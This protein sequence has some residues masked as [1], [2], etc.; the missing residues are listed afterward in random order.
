MKFCPECGSMLYYIEEGS[1]LY[2]KCKSCG[3]STECHDRIIES[4]IYTVS[5]TQISE[6]KSYMRYDS[7]L[8]RTI[9]KECPNEDCQSRKDKVFQE[10]VFYPDPL[11]MKLIY[12]CIICN[13][14]WKYS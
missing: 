1:V 10:A 11:T 7:T 9:H 2:T 12:I 6:N 14:E 13:T 4:S 5:N 8:P 3:Y